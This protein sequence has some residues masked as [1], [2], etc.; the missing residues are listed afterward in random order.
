M[1][2]VLTILYF[3]KSC[4]S[5]LAFVVNKVNVVNLSILQIYNVSLYVHKSFQWKTFLL[6]V[7]CVYYLYERLDIWIHGY[8][9]Y[10]NKNLL[11]VIAVRFNPFTSVLDRMYLDERP[12]WYLMQITRSSH[13]IG[14]YLLFCLFLSHVPSSRLLYLWFVF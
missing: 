2:Y 13:E 1:V 14:F 12:S 6:P 3:S 9:A 4:Q 8:F 10:N 5:D 11:I 7:R